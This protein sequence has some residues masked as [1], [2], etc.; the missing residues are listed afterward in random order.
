MEDTPDNIASQDKTICRVCQLLQRHSL[1]RWLTQ[2][3][4]KQAGDRLGS[5]RSCSRPAF[6]TGLPLLSSAQVS[7]ED[8][9]KKDAKR[10]AKDKML[11]TLPDV[12]CIVKKNWK[13]KKKQQQTGKEAI[14]GIK[15]TNNRVKIS[16]QRPKKC[17]FNWHAHIIRSH[18]LSRRRHLG[19]L[20]WRW[21]WQRDGKNIRG[22][23]N[24]Y[25]KIPIHFK[26]YTPSFLYSLGGQQI[27]KP[28]SQPARMFVNQPAS[29]PLSPSD[30]QSTHHS[31]NQSSSKKVSQPATLPFIQAVNWVSFN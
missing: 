5:C 10:N 8:L 17:A 11:F 27:S 18:S 2:F 16:W 20:R 29:Q 9:L 26:F 13:E 1:M 28:F 30:N 12:A 24:W 15:T 31:A 4:L 22:E 6:F 21:R 3:Q 25:F 7:K 23:E 19:F 14:S